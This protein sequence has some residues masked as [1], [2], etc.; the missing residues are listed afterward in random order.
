M[1]SETQQEIYDLAREFARREVEPYADE[2]DRAAKF[3]PA[4]ITKMAELGL[5]GM[6]APTEWGGVEADT[7][8]LVA[9]VEAIARADA[10]IALI[11][12]MANSLSVRTLLNYGN[13]AQIGKW[14]PAIVSGEAIASF[15]ITESHCGSDPVSMKTRAVRKGKRYVISGEKSFISFGSVAKL[16][17][18]FAVTDPDAGAKGISCFLV[19]SDTPGFSIIRQED[20]LGLRA[21][22]TCQIAFDDMEIDAAQ[23]IGLPG[24]G[25][26]IALDGLGASRIGVAAQSVG[27]AS[28]AFEAASAYARERETFGRKL[29]DHQGVGFRLADMAMEIAAARHL[30]LHAA[31][32]KDQDRGYSAA[33]AMAKTFASEM[34]ERVCSSAIQIFGANGYMSENPVARYYRD[35]RVFQIYEGTT[36]I[37]RIIIARTIA[38]GGLERE[39]GVV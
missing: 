5:L 34:C 23:M 11:V 10:T 36:E 22:D 3:S 31:R 30:T 17:F 32:L 38:Q 14:L 21:S 4:V 26:Q 6:T 13:E 18:L 37:Q 33:S 28:A 20:K 8:S 29:V 9:A 35:A 27:V 15:A 19:P 2:W 1:L 16:C 39:V 7:V 12:S 25:Y 24:A